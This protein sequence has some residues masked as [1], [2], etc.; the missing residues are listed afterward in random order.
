[1]SHQWLF[2]FSRCPSVHVLS[3]TCADQR[4]ATCSTFLNRVWHIGVR[5][6]GLD[7]RKLQM[8]CS[9]KP[10]WR[11]WLTRV[12]CAAHVLCECR[13]HCI[14]HHP[15]TNMLIFRLIFSAVL[16]SFK[17]CRKN[18]KNCDITCLICDMSLKV[19]SNFE[20]RTEIFIIIR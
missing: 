17:K 14:L 3:R 10:H 6:F 9:V 2:S 18:E 7:T 15:L 20:T 11:S 4:L 19:T 8:Q 1:M 12:L 5:S 13:C 16:F